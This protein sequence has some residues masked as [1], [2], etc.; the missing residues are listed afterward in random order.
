M[1][2]GSPE[3]FAARC[4][5]LTASKIADALGKTQ[6]GWGAGRANVMAQLISERLTG[7]PVES[8]QNKEMQWGSETEP[9]A[10][11]AYEFYANVDVEQIG[12]VVH[13]DFPE[14]GASPDGL[15]GND[16]LIEIKCPNTATH[17]DT[18]LGDSIP[19]KYITQMQWQMAC[20]GRKWCDFVSFDPRMPGRMRLHIQRIPRDD[21]LIASLTRDVE[22]FLRELNTKLA[23]LQALYST[24]A[25]A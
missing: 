1:I 10:R 24:E 6:R 21:V 2:Q 22:I 17:I 5:K 14:S 8:Y 4:G 11:D 18:L 12:F 9:L 7:A 19:G 25:A 3:W 23:S 15:V 16:G 20:T 13:P